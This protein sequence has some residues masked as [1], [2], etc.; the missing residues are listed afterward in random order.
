MG[1][2]PI[3]ATLPRLPRRERE[4]HK[5]DY[6]KV[7]I[8]SGRAGYTGAPCLAAAGALRAGAGLV[9]VGVPEAVYPIVAAK[10][11]CAMPYPLPCDDAGGL[12]MS[13]RGPILERCRDADAV[14]IGPGLGRT[15]RT[16]ELIRLL[17]R[18]LECPLVLDADGIN[19]LAGHIDVLDSRRGRVTVLTPHLGEFARLLG[20][21]PEED[22][23]AEALNFAQAH[24]CV[25]ALKGHRTLTA[26]PDGE[27][28]V[29]QTGNPGMAVGGTGDVLGGMILSLL[30]QGFPLGQAVRDGVYLHGLAGDLAAQALGEYAMTAG[31]LLECLP[32]AMKLAEGAKQDKEE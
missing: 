24:G 2:A 17:T 16:P 20:R 11:L 4:S 1:V 21:E 15:G 13:A 27:I 25:L 9:S 29:N 6:G 31:D 26:C 18:R 5:G 10:L 23:A 19:A 12:A 22:R 28:Y 32:Q 7:H 14:L 3:P 8:I 30:G